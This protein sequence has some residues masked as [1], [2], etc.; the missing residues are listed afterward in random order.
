MGVGS[1]KRRQARQQRQT[2]TEADNQ[3]CIE[4]RPVRTGAEAN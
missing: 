3:S 1:M 4:V 2:N